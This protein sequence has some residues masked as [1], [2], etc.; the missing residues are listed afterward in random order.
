LREAH[1]LAL[2]TWKLNAARGVP[3]NPLSDSMTSA[4]IQIW[5]YE[6]KEKGVRALDAALAQTPLRTLR[7]E[8]RGYFQLATFYSWAGRPDKARQI[9]KQ[10]DEEVR[11][12]Q[13]RRV[14]EPDRHFALGE[15]LLAEKK[16]LDA[17]RE[18]WASDSLTDGPS[19]ECARCID[20]DL[21]RAYDLANLPDSAIAHFEAYLADPAV[22]APGRDATVLAG[23]HKR[24]GELYEAK[25]DASRAITHYSRFVELWKNADPELQ[26]KVDDVRK[27]LAALQKRRTG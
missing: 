23:I 14:F 3:Q 9:L 8:Q 6:E 15:I 24:L 10:Y 17:V 4:A 21:G 1:R 12:P 13:W 20:D 11:E 18:F 19:N 27:R 26:P 2:E 5:F 7:V 22:R 16:P 25:G